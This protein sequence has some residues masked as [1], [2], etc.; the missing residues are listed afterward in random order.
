MYIFAY[1][2]LSL[3]GAQLQCVNNDVI[4]RFEDCGVDGDLLLTLRDEHLREDLAV[5]NGVHRLR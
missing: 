1:L 5:T 2:S 4:S 3:I